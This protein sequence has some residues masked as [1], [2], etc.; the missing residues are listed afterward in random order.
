MK[1]L[2]NITTINF[3]RRDNVD[4]NGQHNS[5]RQSG[6]SNNPQ[7]DVFVRSE[8]SS[9]P[10]SKSLFASTQA[11]D[12]KALIGDYKTKTK[13]L[14]LIM[15]DIC[16]YLGKYISSEIPA[17]RFSSLYL[18]R[19]PNFY[20]RI[21]T[22]TENEEYKASYKN[23]IEMIKTVAKACTEYSED[24]TLE[25][26]YDL[27]ATCEAAVIDYVNKPSSRTKDFAL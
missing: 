24:A 3:K 10:L 15:D 6:L 25:S 19:L 23:E 1:I 12:L 14:P 11:T 17:E 7:S 8:G 13:K 4:N 20:K 21:A 16:L 26:K 2:N 27:D 5:Q 18:S 9:A 22:G